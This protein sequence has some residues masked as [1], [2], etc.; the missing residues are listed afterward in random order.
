MFGSSKKQYVNILK[1]NKQLN[2]DY[3]T[4]QDNKVLK[5]EHSSFLL[6]DDSMPQDALF[7]LDTLQKNIPHTYISTLFE[8]DL[9]QV[10]RTTDVDVIGYESVKLDNE[11]SVV[12]PK[13]EIV[14]VSRYFVDSG[15]DYI[16][17]PF[18]ILNEYCQDKSTKNSLNVLIY[19]N[20]VY[21]TILNH[22]KQI[23]HCEVKAL[24]PFDQVPDQEF[25]GDEIVD[26]KIYEEVYF[27]EVQQFLNDIVQNYYSQNE[28]VEF[29]EQVKVLYTLKPLTDEQIKSLYETIMVDVNY[30]AIDMKNYL[31]NITQRDNGS[32]FSFTDV[33]LK[34]KKVNTKPW[35][36]L[37]GLSVIVVAGVLYFKMQ[38][39]DMMD[40]KK[41][42]MSEDKQMKMKKE[43][44]V[45]KQME[46]QFVEIPNHMLKNN[47]ML[48]DIY[49]LFDVVPYDAV[50]KDLEV[51]KDAST[52]VCNFAAGSNSLLDMQTK[53]LNIYKDSKVLLKHQNKAVINTIIENET[54]LTN[55]KTIPLKEYK[56]LQYLPI[57][58]STDYLNSLLTTRSSIKYLSK[59]K[60]E[61]L[62][63]NFLIK[64]LVKTPQDFFDFVEMLSNQKV[65][66][67]ISYPIVFAK[68]N[69]GLEVSFNV[70][71]NQKDKEQVQPKK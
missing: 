36:L 1:Q 6:T 68:I 47:Q 38:E 43:Q 16:V 17:S 55:K 63:Y 15:I 56:N 46:A 19:N 65:A 45:K 20:V 49:M 64:S 67:N 21:I 14:T 13:N 22:L 5:E 26:Q 29:L 39:P 60:K 31:S 8:G 12:I 58:K 7:K 37:A 10:V 70:Q 48:Q 9:Q 18:S 50:L 2:L 69:N 54:I 52:Y 3:K 41:A 35:L 61:Y 23:V 34:E 57:G 4:L 51:L 53:L 66:I 32:R 27:L 71:L 40:E 62:T 28:E 11:Y 33:R 30:E 42:K 25:S 24:T 44:V 59:E